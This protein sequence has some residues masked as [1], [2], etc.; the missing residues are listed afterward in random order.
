MRGLH[1]FDDLSEAPLDSLCLTVSKQTKNWRALPEFTCLEE[2]TLDRPAPAQI[3]WLES[4]P[5][6]KRLRISFSRTKSLEVLRSLPNL[7]ELI[8]EYTSG[9]R[10][11]SA[12]G[13]LKGLRSLH[14]ENLRNVT[15]FSELQSLVSLRAL[16]IR[17]TFDAAQKIDNLDFLSGLKNLEQLSISSSRIGDETH[18][19]EQFQGLKRIQR[20]ALASDQ[21]ELEFFAWL[22]VAFSEIEG[23]TWDPYWIST[24]KAQRVPTGDKFATMPV[25]ELKKVAPDIVIKENGSRWRPAPIEAFLL[26]RGH[27]VAQGKRS[28]VEEKAK[29]HA[30]EYERLKQGFRLGRRN[31]PSGMG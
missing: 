22:S 29:Q 9:I 13:A 17:G 10:D 15:D 3:E 20:F 27:R 12:L 18:L 30:L 11:L 26:G 23:A 1:Q 24:G 5:K 28:T 19:M 16:G 2:L 8:L 14:L 4:L 7:E 21:F 31:G 6:L 25:E